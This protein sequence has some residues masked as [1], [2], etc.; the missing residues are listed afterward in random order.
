MQT[1][2]FPITIRTLKG[3][4]TLESIRRAQEGDL[5]DA[6]ILQNA[7]ALLEES[8][9][10]MSIEA[11]TAAYDQAVEQSRELIR[12]AMHENPPPTFPV[13]EAS[14]FEPFKDEADIC[15]YITESLHRLGRMELQEGDEK[16]RSARAIAHVEDWK[17][18]L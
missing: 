1:L 3:A 16:E 12:E 13:Q 17:A 6:T 11:A 10:E 4:L 14:G 5:V 9:D 8:D 15:D 7:S 2:K 18:S